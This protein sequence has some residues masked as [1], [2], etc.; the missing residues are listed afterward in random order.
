MNFSFVLEHAANQWPDDVAV[1]QGDQCW[2]FSELLSA[3]E[4]LAARL[5]DAGIA[6]WDKVGLLCPSGPQYIVGFFAILRIRGV[7][8]P[9]SPALKAAEVADVTKDTGLK[10]L[11]YSPSFEN[12]FHSSPWKAALEPSMGPNR[13]PLRIRPVEKWPDDPAEHERL[14]GLNAASIRFSSGTTSDAKGIILSHKSIQERGQSH[15]LAGPIKKKDTALW[16]QTTAR[17]LPG[18][19]CACLMQGAKLIF[20]DALATGTMRRLIKE[21]GV[22]QIY[23]TPIFYQ[24]LLNEPDMTSDDLRNVEQLSTAG[25]AVGITLAEAFA[26]KFGRGIL[27]HY[28]SAETG[29]VFLNH[30][31]DETKRGSVGRIARPDYEVQLVP[32]T[33]EM[34]AE[35]FIGEIWVRSPALF[36][37]YHKPWRPIGEILEDGWFRTGDLARRDRDGYYWIIGRIKEVINVGGVK[38]FPAEIEEV[39]LTHPAVDEAMVY[40]A[41][42]PRFGE[43]PHA[44]VKLRNGI[45]CEALDVLRY[46]NKQISVFKALRAVEFVDEIPKTVTGKARRWGIEGRVPRAE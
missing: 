31:E 30:D 14:E 2:R 45:A 44:K 9:I 32:V 39:L 18:V 28:G 1:I 46:V 37:G 6:A 3:A 41:P 27:Q 36:A 15:V 12:F 19:I 35:E 24:A 33:G 8:V 5:T 16:L 7:V 4:F 34:A 38:V 42:E 25:S 13:T 20:G 29:E 23:A 10:A 21:H 26:A 17:G 22:T 40:G 43:V 11:C